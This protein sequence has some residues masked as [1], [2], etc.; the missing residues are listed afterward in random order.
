[1]IKEFSFPILC[2]LLTAASISGGVVEKY[3]NRI[4]EDQSSEN[5]IDN[6]KE[7]DDFIESLTYNPDQVLAYRGESREIARKDGSR[8][9]MKFIVVSREHKSITNGKADIGVISSVQHKTFP[10]SILQANHHL[11]DNSPNVVALTREPLMYTVDLPGMTED[12][13]FTIVPSY[14]NYRAKLNEVLNK[15]F[16]DYEPNHDVVALFQSD[17][18]LVYSLDQLRVKF[19]MEVK[20][21]EADLAIDFDAVNRQEKSIMIMRFRQVFYTVSVESPSRP[22]ELFDESVGRSQL[23]KKI[24]NNNPPVMVDSVS[25]GRVIYVKIE[26]TSTN[27][28]AKA[29]LEAS[30]NQMKTAQG[31]VSGGM[32]KLKKLDNLQMHVYVTGGGAENHIELIRTSEISEIK[33][34][35]AKYGKFNRKNL[36]FPLTYACQFVKDNRRA[37]VRGTADYTETNR[38]EHGAGIIRLSMKGWYVGQFHVTWDQVSYDAYGNKRVSRQAWPKN[39]EDLTRGFT[40]ELYLSGDTENLRISARV[41]TFLAWEWWRTVFDRSEIPLIG[42]REFEIGGTSLDADYTITPRI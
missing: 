34:I 16:E 23:A 15:W 28:E 18:S 42:F 2:L 6:K 8:D 20:S 36:G 11:I 17:H 5:V 27:S 41:C 33:D 24:N 10:G 37:V 1:M 40:E 4:T 39:H 29:N 32:E 19:G 9:G 14:S 22:S 25:Y 31:K 7:V 30:V 13:S 21:V 35:V 38:E 26:T 3:S 12:G